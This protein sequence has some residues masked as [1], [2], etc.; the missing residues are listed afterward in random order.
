MNNNE[1]SHPKA[2]AEAREQFLYVIL[3][4]MLIAGTT[5]WFGTVFSSL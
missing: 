2:V 5:E 4:M 3:A 1:K